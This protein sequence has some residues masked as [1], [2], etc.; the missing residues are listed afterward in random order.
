MKIKVQMIFNN[1]KLNIMLFTIMLLFLTIWLYKFYDS[2]KLILLL[3]SIGAVINTA[4][5]KYEEK[6]NIIFNLILKYRYLFALIAFVFCVMFKLH[7]S[8]VGVFN[9][10][11]PDKIDNGISSQVIGEARA[12]RSDEY[13]VQLP[14]YFSQYYNNYSLSSQQMSLAGQDMIIGYNAPVK[15]ITMIAKPFTLGYIL[16]GNEIGLSWYWCSKL[17]LF[18]LVAYEA[19]SIMTKNNK[20]LSVLGSFLV[21]FS[22]AMQWWF[23]PHMYDVF[24]WSTSLYVLGYY[25]FVARDKWFKWLITILSLCGIVGF[26]IALFPS[27]QVALGL[28]ALSVLIVTLVR[29]KEIITFKKNDISRIIIVVIGVGLILGRYAFGSL[30]E[31]ILL[32]STV[33][34]GNRISTGGGATLEMFFFDITNLLTPY[35]DINILNNCEISRFFHLGMLFLLYFPFMLY[36]W[37]KNNYKKSYN[38]AIGILL[39]ITIII[40]V[41]FLVIGFPEWLAKITLFSYINRMNLVYSF[42]ALL[43][44]IWSI[45][46]ISKNKELQNIR[47]GTV[48]LV[49]FALLY[50]K[51][52]APSS[53]EYIGT[54][55][56][57]SWVPKV[58]FIFVIGIFILIGILVFINN[59]EMSAYLLIALTIFSTWTINPIVKGTS[60]ITNN[61]IYPTIQEIVNKDDSNWLSIGT[62]LEQNYLI[63]V[64]AKCLNAVNFYPD[65]G[66]W[67]LIDPELK[68]DYFYNRYIH[69]LV[70]LTNEETKY[71]LVTPDCIQIDL[72]VSDLQKWDV[73]Y[74]LSTVDI[75]EL[76]VSNNIK[77]N[78]SKGDS[79]HFIYKLD[80]LN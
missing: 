16:F 44:T 59:M 74:L 75:S 24:F 11:F 30:E 70:N 13:N 64:G 17:I 66:K 35:K 10:V 7:G 21:V 47:Y 5:L 73:T 28:I 78:M 48:C 38:M 20:K 14:Y 50:Y 43:F 8:S 54:I 55:T 67:K 65:Y 58:F 18:L 22:P 60:A 49:I 12:L 29:D 45:D 32:N 63:T 34:P 46:A 56:N 19:F 76:L 41:I 80:Y 42:S 36:K 15:D 31:I 9:G 25:F 62:M 6:I 57:I 79:T 61:K 23:S 69:M 53:F 4:R 27:L 26:V 33:Y 39:I 71:T 77:Y 1:H 2:S 40:E 3:G 52:I 51:S 68:N 72:S 37:K